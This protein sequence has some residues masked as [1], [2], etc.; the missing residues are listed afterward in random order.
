VIVGAVVVLAA[1]CSGSSVPEGIPIAVRVEVV[2][3]AGHF[4]NPNVR[5]AQPLSVYNTDADWTR[6]SRLL[7]D[8]L[9]EP[10]DQGSDCASGLMVSVRLATKEELTGEVNY[11][12]CC[13]PKQVEPVRLLMHT[14]L[15]RKF[16]AELRCDCP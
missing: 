15:R 7:P 9:P 16:A 12:P 13:W 10:V 8:R 4:G 3:S 11:G 5:S 14:L 2:Q 6:V 1:G